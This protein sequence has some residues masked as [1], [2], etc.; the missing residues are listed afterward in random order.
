[1]CTVMWRIYPVM[2]LSIQSSLSC[3]VA[4]AWMAKLALSPAQISFLLGTSLVSSV[5][6]LGAASIDYLQQIKHKLGSVI[7]LGALGYHQCTQ[8]WG[9]NAV[10]PL[11]WKGVYSTGKLWL[12]FPC[13]AI[14][15]PFLP[16]YWWARAS[17]LSTINLSL[18]SPAGIWGMITALALVWE[19]ARPRHPLANCLALPCLNCSPLASGPVCSN[20]GSEEGR[21]NWST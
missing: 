11:P 17:N 5:G 13:T 16:C 3:L 20:K 15:S 18:C 14:L 9:I 21:G 1:M 4:G 6:L 19:P 8:H 2:G 7:L 12:Q 10:V